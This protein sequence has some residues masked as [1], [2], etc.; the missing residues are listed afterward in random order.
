[1]SGFVVRLDARLWEQMKEDLERG[2]P[3]VVKRAIRRSVGAGASSFRV[4]LR[5]ATYSNELGWEPLSDVTRVIPVN[6]PL[7]KAERTTKRGKKKK[8]RYNRYVRKRGGKTF[9][10][11]L[12]KL[13]NVFRYDLSDE[14]VAKP[15]AQVG[16]LESWVGNKVARYF[17]AFQTRGPVYP[18]FQGRLNGTGEMSRYFGSLG[19]K[20]RKSKNII[21]PK[22]DLVAPLWEKKNK[23]IQSLMAVKFAERLRKP[24]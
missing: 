21:R 15:F 11:F 4:M 6:P 18:T 23:A 1:M 10:G 16:V 3:D 19:F 22:R 5:A 7:D 14:S 17:A 24:K 12:G 13:K 20:L 2:K 9:G 8:R